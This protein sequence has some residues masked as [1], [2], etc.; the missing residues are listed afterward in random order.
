MVAAEGS[1]TANAKTFALAR[2]ARRH[3]RVQWSDQ[4]M[5][6]A[7]A[8]VWRG[9]LNPGWNASCRSRRRARLCSQA[10]KRSYENPEFFDTGSAFFGGNGARSCAIV[11][12]I[13]HD[14]G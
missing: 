2:E 1:E 10:R 12:Q 11:V 7:L 14:W 6:V 8:M 3:T 13:A 5:A 9:N 4:P